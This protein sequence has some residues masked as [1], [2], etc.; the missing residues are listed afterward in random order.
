MSRLS[1]VLNVPEGQEFEYKNNGY[2][3]KIEDGFLQRKENG[4]WENLNSLLCIMINHTENIIVLKKPKLTKKQKTAI[5]GRIAEGTP[6]A[7][8]NKGFDDTVIFFE[9]KPILDK[10]CDLWLDHTERLVHTATGNVKMFDFIKS[11]ECVYLPDLMG[12]EEE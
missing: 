11:G 1:E 10:S 2:V 4:N 5:K 3:Y 7:A 8:I 6:W 9:R 12:D